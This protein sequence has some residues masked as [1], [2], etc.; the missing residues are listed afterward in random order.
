MLFG[1]LVVVY[2]SRRCGFWFVFLDFRLDCMAEY[3]EV[4]ERSSITRYTHTHTPAQ[5]IYN[6]LTTHQEKVITSLGVKIEN[7]YL[8][9]S[10]NSD[11]PL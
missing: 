10:E 9:L 11:I 6:F 3:W 5:V 4:V 1:D 2:E 7:S 8:L